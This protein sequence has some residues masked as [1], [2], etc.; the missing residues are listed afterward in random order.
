MAKTHRMSGR[1]ASGGALA[2][3]PAA[4]HRGRTRGVPTDY[5]H[6]FSNTFSHF[7][8]RLDVFRRP[9][10]NRTSQTSNLAKKGLERGGCDQQSMGALV[11]PLWHAAAPGLKPLR[12]PRAQLQIIFRKRATNHRALQ[13]MTCKDKASYGSSPPCIFGFE[14]TICIDT[15]VSVC[16]RVYRYTYIHMNTCT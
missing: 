4:R 9:I 8:L 10:L 11:R 13:K 12:L 2:P 14:Q 16:E 3:Q 7:F 15:C 6:S 1:A 5:C